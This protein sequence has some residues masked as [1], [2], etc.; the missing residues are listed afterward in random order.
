MTGPVNSVLGIE[1]AQSI[2]KFMGDPPR[3]YESAKGPSKME[4]C[5][6]EID[7]KTG[8]CLKAEGIRLT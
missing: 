5:I 8:R 7:E 3:R 2:G 4:G 1:P 6:F